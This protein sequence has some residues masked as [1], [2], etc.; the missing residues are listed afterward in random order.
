[1]PKL[2][3]AFWVVTNR[4]LESVP[5][6][7]MMLSRFSRLHTDNSDAFS[8]PRL[9]TTNEAMMPNTFEDVKRIVSVPHD[10]AK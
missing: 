7:A 6:N 10:S 3:R 9:C 4:L 2:R 8:R 1:M 5:F